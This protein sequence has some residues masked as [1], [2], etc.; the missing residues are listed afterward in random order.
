MIIRQYFKTE[1]GMVRS[2]LKATMPAFLDG[3][4]VADGRIAIATDHLLR[5][6]EKWM[7]II[8]ASFLSA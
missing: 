7:Q 8:G 3:E 2:K 1:D 5:L 6:F 4:G